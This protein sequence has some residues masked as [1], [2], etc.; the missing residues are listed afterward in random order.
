MPVRPVILF[1]DPVLKRVCDPADPGDPH[2]RAVALDLIETLDSAPGV[3]IA[4]PQIGEPLRIA[5]IDAT[6]SL[7]HSASAQGRFVLFNPE[8]VS[9][10]G[11]QL[12]REGC[13]SIPEYT[14]NVRRAQQVK[15]RALGLEGAD[16]QVTAEG[17]EAVVFQH[18]LDHLD[19]ILFLDRIADVK[20]DLFRRRPRRE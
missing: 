1:P 20:S 9:R 16:V 11:E 5:V 15:V 6:R 8:I 17:F 2:H 7:R 18:E 12:F 10:N 4:A 13:L 19:G 14:G 3:G